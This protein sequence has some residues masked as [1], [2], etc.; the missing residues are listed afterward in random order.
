MD[1]AEARTKGH[2]DPDRT[3]ELIV[4]AATTLF[5]E[6][7]FDGATA[8]DI[9][10]A[11]GVN[12]AMINYHFRGK[13]GLYRTILDELLGRV[14]EELQAIARAPL[15][16]QERLG[17]YLDV[18]AALHREKPATSALLMR[19]VLSGGRFLEATML[20][21]FLAVFRSIQSILAVGAA[22]GSFQSVEPLMTHLTIMGGLMFFFA[23]APFRERLL[24]AAPIAITPPTADDFIAHLK[25]LLAH[26]LSRPEGESR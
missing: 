1:A 19:E 20:T 8:E 10:R 4:E 9:A 5:S 24:A 11:A 15:A 7:G 18:F 12:K 22:D 21:R 26:G 13:E 23:S 2:R 14:A 17:R 6:R 3:R 16:S 25:H